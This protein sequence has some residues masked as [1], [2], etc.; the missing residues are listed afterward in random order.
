MGRGPR[1]EEA[2]TGA[3]AGPRRTAA[4]NQAAESAAAQ[5]TDTAAEAHLSPD[6]GYY[7]DDAPAE[8]AKPAQ[9][10]FDSVSSARRHMAGQL[11]NRSV[12]NLR[13]RVAAHVGQTSAGRLIEQMSGEVAEYRDQLSIKRQVR[14]QHSEGAI[15]S[16]RARRAQ[17]SAERE[18][19]AEQEIVQASISDLAKRQESYYGDL[20]RLSSEAAAGNELAANMIS[21]LDPAWIDRKLAERTEPSEGEI[22]EIANRYYDVVNKACDNAD[23]I[24]AERRRDKEIKDNGGRLVSTAELGLSDAEVTVGREEVRAARLAHAN[25]GGGGMG[26]MGGEGSMGGMGMGRRQGHQRPS[27]MPRPSR[28]ARPSDLEQW[29]EEFANFLVG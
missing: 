26:G 22:G 21:V 1:S 20:A 29:S 15:E 10:E 23:Q 28:Q 24:I 27:G 16:L 8:P 3:V 4:R 17:R 5:P 2:L 12:N 18:A 7:Q 11:L 14:A 25:S 9:K 19:K 6:A 13:E